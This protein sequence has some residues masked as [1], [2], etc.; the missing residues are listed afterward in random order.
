MGLVS[1]LVEA[2]GE[3]LYFVARELEGKKRVLKARINKEAR[4]EQS[5][6]FEGVVTLTTSE[7][8]KNLMFI[9]SQRKFAQK[10]HQQYYPNSTGRYCVF[11]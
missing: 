2:R 10:Q 9:M 3:S 6:P 11:C 4:Y 8:F 1:G 7:T 5:L